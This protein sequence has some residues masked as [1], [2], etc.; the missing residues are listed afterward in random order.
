MHY[1]N[2]I[3]LLKK[4]QIALIDLIDSIDANNVL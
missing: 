1:S 4:N 2:A 3:L